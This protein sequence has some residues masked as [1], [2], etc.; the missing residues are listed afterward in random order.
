VVPE[1][2]GAEFKEWIGGHYENAFS[3]NPIWEPAYSKFP[4]HPIT[5]GVKPFQ[6][7]DEWYFHI[8][9]RPPFGHGTEPA[10]DGAMKFVPILVAAPSD[11]TRDGPYVYPPGPYPH[12][13]AEKGSPE[14]TMWAVERPDGGRGFGFTG[15]HFHRNW[16]NAEFRRTIL[17]ALVWITKAE[18]PEGGIVADVTEAELAENLDPKPAPKKK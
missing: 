7:K 13:Q 16:G 8:R 2:G 14:T 5:R 11:T 15:G 10:T 4:D 6:I 1:L 9:F 17:N 3:C 12:I 18:V